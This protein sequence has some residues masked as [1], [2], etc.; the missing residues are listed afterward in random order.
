MLEAITAPVKIMP[1]V[2]DH[3]CVLALMLNNLCLSGTVH[4]YDA[5]YILNRSVPRFRP[6]TDYEKIERVK[7]HLVAESNILPLTEPV[8]SP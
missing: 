3:F 5:E 4:N 6:P 1:E 7:T 2:T 8:A